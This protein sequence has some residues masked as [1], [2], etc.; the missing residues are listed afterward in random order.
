MTTLRTGVAGL[1]A[2]AMMSFGAAACTP[3]QQ[4]QVG[5]GLGQVV[6]FYLYLAILQTACAGQVGHD[7]G[8]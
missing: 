2:V 4:A 6:E 3:E 8:P 5:T 7:C 1:V